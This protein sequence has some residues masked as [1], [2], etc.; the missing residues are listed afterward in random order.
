MADRLIEVIVSGSA[1]MAVW[2][3]YVTDTEGDGELTPIRARID[4][5]EEQRATQTAASVLS[6]GHYLLC[7]C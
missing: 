3:S 4:G 5:E 6:T 7:L 1:G 2:A